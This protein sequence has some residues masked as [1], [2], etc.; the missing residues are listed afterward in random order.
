MNSVKIIQSEQQTEY[1]VIPKTVSKLAELYDQ[2]VTMEL[3]GT[4]STAGVY[5]EDKELLE[6]EFPK[7]HIIAS[8]YYIKFEDPVTENIIVRNLYNR[9][10]CD[11]YGITKTEAAT[12]N[13]AANTFSSVLS[14]YG[15]RS[16]VKKFNELKYFPNITSINNNY[17]YACSV[18][19]SIDLSNITSLSYSGGSSSNSSNGIFS[20]CT[21]LVNLGENFKPE[22]IGV[23]TF[24]GCSKLPYID[25]SLTQQIGYAAFQGCSSLE[26][27]NNLQNLVYIGQNAFYNCSKL[28]IEDL[29]CP[30]LIGAITTINDI[31]RNAILPYTFY[32]T[33]IKEISDLGLVTYISNYAFSDCDSLTEVTLSN[34][35]VDVG[36]YVFSDCNNLTSVTLSNSL[37]NIGK[38]MFSGCQK[39]ETI[40]IPNSVINIKTQAFYNC[41]KLSEIV[42]PDNVTNIESQAFY[43]C[44]AL[45]NVSLSNNLSSIKDYTFYQCTSLRSIV[46]PDSVKTIEYNAF[47]QCTNLTNLDLGEGVEQIAGGAF[48]G[49]S[50]IVTITG[51]DSLTT[52]A[53]NY[54]NNTS[55]YS[56]YSDGLIYLGNLAYK[57]KGL[58]SSNSVIT[59]REGTTGIGYEAFYQQYNTYTVEVPSSLSG[60]SAKAF[61]GSS[62]TSSNYQN[63]LKNLVGFENTHTKSIGSSAFYYCKSLESITFPD[64]LETIGTEAFYSCYNLTSIDTNNVKSIDNYCF[65]SCTGLLTITLGNSLE[66]LGSWAFGGCTG[67]TSITIPNSLEIINT[68]T[69]YNCS[70]LVQV[71]FGNNLKQIGSYAFYGCTT[72]QNVSIPDSVTTIGQQAF[73]GCNIIGSITLG[74]GVT[75]IDSRAFYNCLGTITINS[76]ITTGTSILESSRFNNL[77][78]GNEIQNIKSSLFSSSPELVSVTFGNQVEA[79]GSNAF[80][81]CPKLHNLT[82]NGNIK[83]IGEY[84]FQGSNLE[85]FTVQESTVAIDYNPFRDCKNLTSLSVSNNN[86]VYD[87]RDNCNAI[88]VTASNSLIVGCQNTII[89]NT[90]VNIGYGAFQGC[91]SLTSIVIP[92]SVNTISSYAFSGCTGLTSIDL[93]NVTN[94]KTYAFS[95]CTGLTSITIP[96]T[97]TTVESSIFNGCTG[98]TSVNIQNST[99]GTEEFVGCTNIT[100]LTIGE[101][102][103]TISS[104]AFSNCKNLTNVTISSNNTKFKMEGNSIVTIPDSSGNSTLIRATKLLTEI[105]NT[106]TEIGS[107]AFSG[108]THI[109]SIVIPENVKSIGPS[110]FR[111]ASNLTS[112]VINDGVTK[113]NTY[114]FVGCPLNSITL[115]S[116]ITSLAD[117]A[118]TYSTS[119][120]SEYPKTV[121]IKRTT[122]PSMS[123]YTTFGYLSGNQQRTLYVPHG[124]KT[125]YQNAYY[126][127]SS[128]LFTSIIELPE[129]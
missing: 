46:I 123:S 122:P 83:S 55:W 26:D 22:I 38:Y 76:Y 65:Y 5:E 28:E 37:E 36:D 14:F 96:N 81:T 23:Y 52:T 47:Y 59:L 79:I 90:I 62:S 111:A 32:K 95:G 1:N 107:Y 103:T 115:P 10:I 3:Q 2:D 25:L 45:T 31:Q 61:Y 84:A 51:G 33:K 42:I 21:Q 124:C 100:D 6:Q 78:I 108:L 63:K 86:L 93:S 70:N 15:H 53:D 98:L 101:L 9:N 20:G 19:T 82:F 24:Y 34:P 69:F 35:I 67:L 119:S 91:T 94:I 75:R 57:H 114:T 27:I 11:Q 74:S 73:Y 60:I 48:Y 41:K 71:N 85:S 128:S 117:H 50:N 54:F 109:T 113:I 66:N 88:I 102:T 39:L 97:V 58:I 99:V 116:T 16:Q 129:E 17:F 125:A 72:L 7:F 56:A 121:I 18:L 40:T 77:I 64:T 4:I 104:S 87:S 13:N 112:V 120:Y 127:G 44:S 106:V 29:N 92:S 126:W 43:G 105:P 8:K 118:F 89:P 80:S 68:Y 110:A 12:A 30:L 49:C